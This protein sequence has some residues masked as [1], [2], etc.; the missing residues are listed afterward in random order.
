MTMEAV[1]AE[2]RPDI[3]VEIDRGAGGGG[4]REG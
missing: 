4:D 2:D 1:R 3:A